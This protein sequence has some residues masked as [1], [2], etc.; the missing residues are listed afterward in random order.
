MGA[1]CE[2][3]KGKVAVTSSTMELEVVEAASSGREPSRE[4]T[5]GITHGS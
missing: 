5:N 4:L 2:W 3:L 1:Q